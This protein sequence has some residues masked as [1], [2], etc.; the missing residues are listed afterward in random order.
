M[1]S[2]Q[3][4]TSTADRKHESKLST[5]SSLQR[6]PRNCVYKHSAHTWH[7]KGSGCSPASYH[8]VWGTVV[9]TLCAHF[10]EIAVCTDNKL[11]MNW[12]LTVVKMQSDS[13]FI[14]FVALHLRANRCIPRLFGDNE[15][16]EE[17]LVYYLAFS[18]PLMPLNAS[19]KS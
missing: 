12:R 2:C 13:I 15:N 6:F 3:V 7:G 4:D 19:N 18:C 1:M 9:E 10:G 17:N 8:K 11:G 16:Y 14:F 5:Y